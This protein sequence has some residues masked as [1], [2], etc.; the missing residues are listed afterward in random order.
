MFD[1]VISGGD[2]RSL[3]AKIAGMT[4]L[5]LLV[6]LILV[7]FLTSKSL[8]MLA[9]AVRCEVMNRLAGHLNTAAGWQAIERGTGGTILSS[10]KPSHELVS[11]FDEVVVKGDAEVA[12]ANSI[13]EEPSAGGA[14]SDHT[15]HSKYASRG[16]DDFGK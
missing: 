12:E 2:M 1:F 7:V 13:A 16:G 4:A 3:Q 15:L 5:M 11:R 14:G 9:L 6:S 8:E 10:E